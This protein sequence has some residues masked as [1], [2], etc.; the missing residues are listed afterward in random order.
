LVRIGVLCSACLFAVG[1]WA[2]ATDPGPRLVDRRCSA[3]FADPDATR[4]PH[5]TWNET[6]TDRVEPVVVRGRIVRRGPRDTDG[7]VRL[8]VAGGVDTMTI[9][10]DGDELPPEATAHR[11]VDVVVVRPLSFRAMGTDVAA[12]AVHLAE[13]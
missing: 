6:E 8:T 7:T 11:S 3:Y 13:P 1:L 2:W 10:V 4:L 12:C 9:V 5:V